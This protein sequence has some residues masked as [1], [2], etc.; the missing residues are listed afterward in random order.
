M[1]SK[2][3]LWY[4]LDTM[5]DKITIIEGPPPVFEAVS[6]GWALSLNESA[7]LSVP[8]LT[9]LRTF[10]GPA[11]VERCYRA[12]NAKTPIHL[13]YRNDMGLEQSAPILA[14]R[15]VETSDGHVLLLWVYLDHEK[16]EY[17]FD[18]GDEDTDEGDFE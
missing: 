13:Q 7:G 1:Y 8:A 4:I 2:G 11:L 12:W 17:E 6:D 14:A 10:N 16:V 5:E 18:A 9:R 3:L 15:N